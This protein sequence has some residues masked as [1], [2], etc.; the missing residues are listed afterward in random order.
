MNAM[1][2]AYTVFSTTSV[3]YKASVKLLKQKKMV[4]TVYKNCFARNI[5]ASV[6]LD[7]RKEIFYQ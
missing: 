2:S 6:K 4:M 5:A 7:Y 3:W 1:E